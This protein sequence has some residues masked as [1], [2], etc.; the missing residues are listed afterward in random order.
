MSGCYVQKSFALPKHQHA[1]RRRP[2]ELPK[3]HPMLHDRVLGKAESE[4]KDGKVFAYVI[5]NVPN[6]PKVGRAGS[7]ELR[8]SALA[9]TAKNW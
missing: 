1:M 9:S 8:H 4:R 5:T 7:S 3:G 6:L 2:R